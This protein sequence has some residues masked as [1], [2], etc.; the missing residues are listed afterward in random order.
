MKEEERKKVLRVV[1]LDTLRTLKKR[2][3]QYHPK[4][5]GNTRIWHYPRNLKKIV[6]KERERNNDVKCLRF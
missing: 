4:V 1:S 2:V 3:R 6:F 5:R